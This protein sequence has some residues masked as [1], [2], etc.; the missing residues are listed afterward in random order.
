VAGKAAQSFCSCARASSSC[1]NRTLGTDADGKDADARISL[2]EMRA[3]ITFTQRKFRGFSSKITDEGL[4]V[5]VTAPIIDGADE[6]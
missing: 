2:G 5:S 4:A 3:R 1:F 6:G